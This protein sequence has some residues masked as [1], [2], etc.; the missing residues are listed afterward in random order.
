MPVA[1]L[2]LTSHAVAG[3]YLRFP[4]FTREK[5]LH[6]RVQIFV[7][8]SY[9]NVIRFYDCYDFFRFSRLKNVG[10]TF[11]SSILSQFLVTIIS[12]VRFMFFIL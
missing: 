6:S 8:L 3:A 5:S 2:T 9:P 10:S 4:Y 12:S 1:R 11:G 7:P